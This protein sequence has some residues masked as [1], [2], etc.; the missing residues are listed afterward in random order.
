MTAVRGRGQFAQRWAS[1]TEKVR[2]RITQFFDGWRAAV[3]AQDLALVEQ[4]LS[5]VSPAADRL[6]RRMPVDAQAHSLPRGQGAASR[7]PHPA[8]SRRSCAAARRWQGG[9]RRCRGLS[10]VVDTRPN[11]AAGGLASGYTG[12]AGFVTA[13]SQRALCAVRPSFASTDRCSMGQGGRLQPPHLLADCPPSR[14][15]RRRCAGGA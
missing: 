13:R 12:R 2:Y 14:S 8:R 9:G 6:F 4:V 5:P 15:E 11:R 3:T 10:G 1:W 7:R